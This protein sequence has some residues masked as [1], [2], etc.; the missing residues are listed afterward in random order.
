MSN[1]I[2][3]ISIVI[4]LLILG[5]SILWAIKTDFDYEPIII[6]LG[7]ILAL[8]VILFGDRI[9]NKFRI[10]NISQSKVKINTHMQDDAEYNISDVKNN[11]EININKR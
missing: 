8:T 1:I 9:Y 4:N 7:Q 11:S 10:E 3:K 5:L 6:C 2:R